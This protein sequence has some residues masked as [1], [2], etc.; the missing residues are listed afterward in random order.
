MRLKAMRQQVSPRNMFAVCH[1]G[2]VDENHYELEG[3]KRKEIETEET[4]ARNSASWLDPENR[5]FLRTACLGTLTT[6]L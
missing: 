5:S 6:N 1:T 4:N 3:L 2:S